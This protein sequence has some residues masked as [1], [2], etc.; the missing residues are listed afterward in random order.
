[1]NDLKIFLGIT[2]KPVELIHTLKSE[3]DPELGRILYK[4]RH[5]SL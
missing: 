2:E 3:I 5:I 4:F 1:M